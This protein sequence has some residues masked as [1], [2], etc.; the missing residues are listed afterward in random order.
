M[1]PCKIRQAQTLP[2]D[3]LLLKE[4][5][6]NRCSKY[7]LG[8]ADESPVKAHAQPHNDIGTL[9]LQVKRL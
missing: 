9:V 5:Q 1:L 2:C 7:R 6:Y 3:P 4:K 8:V